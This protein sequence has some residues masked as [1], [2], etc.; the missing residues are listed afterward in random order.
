ME[1]VGVTQT[2]IDK[3]SGILW[4]QVEFFRKEVEEFQVQDLY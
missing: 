1:I 2:V 3:G 4:S